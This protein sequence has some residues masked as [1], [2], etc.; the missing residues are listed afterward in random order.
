MR[1]LKLT[2]AYDGRP[3]QGWQSQAGGVTVQ[4]RLETVLGTLAGKR[5]VIHGSGRTDA[6]VHA[7]GQVAHITV[8]DSLWTAAK[9][10][11]AMNAKLPTSIRVTHCE[12]VP[13]DF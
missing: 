1:R 11:R 9:W 8:D 12:E 6:G 2:I 7:R 13:M 4:D 3:W 5:I 10:L